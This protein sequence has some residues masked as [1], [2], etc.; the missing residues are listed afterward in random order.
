MK[1]HPQEE[2]RSFADA[3]GQVINDYQAE[4]EKAWLVELKKKYPVAVNEKI[5]SDVLKKYRSI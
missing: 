3:K 2:P 1:L 5:C 4:L